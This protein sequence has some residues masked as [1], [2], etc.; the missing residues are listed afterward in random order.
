[1]Q[2]SQAS[3]TPRQSVSLKRA[4]RSDLDTPISSLWSPC[5]AS[6]LPRCG[7]KG[8]RT[9]RN[10]RTTMKVEQAKQIASK[11]IQ[12]LSEALERGHS[13]TLRMYLAAI[14][15]FHRYSLHNIILIASQ[16]ADATRVAGF[17]TW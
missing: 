7:V 10:R 15:M 11:A 12:Q 1:N 4:T 13:E 5:F 9:P 3:I 17:H 6:L 14:A 8:A 16:R 2:S